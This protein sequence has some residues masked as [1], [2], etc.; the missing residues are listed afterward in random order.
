MQ[1][2]PLVIILIS[3]NVC[4]ALPAPGE[5][6]DDGLSCY[7]SRGYQ[8]LEFLNQNKENQEYSQ[9]CNSKPAAC[10]AFTGFGDGEEYPFDL[11][12]GN[13]NNN[14]FPED[15]SGCPDWKFACS[16]AYNGTSRL[17]SFGYGSEC[18]T[19]SYLCD[20]EDDCNDGSD[21]RL[22]YCMARWSNEEIGQFGCLGGKTYHQAE[23]LADVIGRFWN[24]R[25]TFLEQDFTKGKGKVNVALSGAQLSGLVSTDFLAAFGKVLRREPQDVEADLFVKIEDLT[26][27]LKLSVDFSSAYKSAV[28][29]FG[30]RQP[31]WRISFD[32]VLDLFDG[33]YGIIEQSIVGDLGATYKKL[34]P[35]AKWISRN[36]NPSPRYDEFGNYEGRNTVDW[37]SFKGEKINVDAMIK[38]N[39]GP[40]NTADVTFKGEVTEAFAAFMNQ[41]FFAALS[42][43]IEFCDDEYKCK[44]LMVCGTDNCNTFDS[45]EWKASLLAQPCPA[46]KWKNGLGGCQDCQ[47]SKS[48]STDNE[49]NQETGQCN[50]KPGLIGK[51]CD[52][53]PPLS[54]RHV[55]NDIETPEDLNENKDCL[56]S[57]FCDPQSVELDRPEWLNQFD[58][59]EG[60][61]SCL[62][63]QECK[64]PGQKGCPTACIFQ[65]QTKKK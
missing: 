33:T 36:A 30:L 42:G 49:C 61:F 59:E 10:F 31:Y 64:I 55:K 28:K 45:S 22:D 56:D 26:V 7:I 15:I 60:C 35:F 12:H 52:K 16:S 8:S 19:R 63:I 21:E 39:G 13:P 5:T 2:L 41:G 9:S 50:C 17:K 24:N 20:G 25:K 4:Q 54:I 43:N 27:K 48:G 32:E 37:S 58:Y 40:D 18:I 14:T 62:S 46:G 53:C 6:V 47:C 23:T 3:I 57:L 1:Y 34:S 44:R 51:E 11:D 65:L 38:L 29:F